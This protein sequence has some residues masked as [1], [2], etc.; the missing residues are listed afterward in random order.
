MRPFVQLQRADSF[1]VNPSPNFHEF[2]AQQPFSRKS[3]FLPLFSHCPHDCP[4]QCEG[5]HRTAPEQCESATPGEGEP[6]GAHWAGTPSHCSGAVRNFRSQWRTRAL[7]WRCA[8]VGLWCRACVLVWRRLD[9]SGPHRYIGARAAD[10]VG[11]PVSRAVTQC[12]CSVGF[13][14]TVPRFLRVLVSCGGFEFGGGAV[15]ITSPQSTLSL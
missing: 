1:F 14:W 4:G 6:T 5:S 9:I 7:G 11:G 13:Q 8:G 10:P 2:F 15:M 12:D 3:H